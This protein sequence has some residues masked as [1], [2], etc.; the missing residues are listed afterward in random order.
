MTPENTS[1]T[2]DIPN[3]TIKL[4]PLNRRGSIVTFGLGNATITFNTRKLPTNMIEAI[5]GDSTSTAL[6]P[7]MP[8]K[9]KRWYAKP[10]NVTTKQKILTGL[11]GKW[12]PLDYEEA[13]GGTYEEVSTVGVVQHG[14]GVEDIIPDAPRLN[15]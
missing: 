5:T 4:T 8:F 12:Y 7:T 2:W 13:N 1:V 15:W 9:L 14:Y 11:D 10:I 6:F 3:R